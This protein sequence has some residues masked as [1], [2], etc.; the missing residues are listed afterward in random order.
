MLFF[1]CL[2]LKKTVY[3]FGYFD[4]NSY[5]Y[6]VLGRGMVI[7]QSVFHNCTQS[8]LLVF[9]GLFWMRR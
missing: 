8:I 5:L 2:F 4:I 7:W 3:V 6:I 9:D 1:L